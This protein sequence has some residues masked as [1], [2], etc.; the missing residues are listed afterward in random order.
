MKLPEGLSVSNLPTDVYN[1][2]KISK[3]FEFQRNTKQAILI[4][5]GIKEQWLPLSVLRQDNNEEI[6]VQNWFLEKNLINVS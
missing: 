4:T 3:F 2:T 5:K 1:H 6:W